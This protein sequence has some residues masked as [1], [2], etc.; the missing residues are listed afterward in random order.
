MFNNKRMNAAAFV[1]PCLFRAQT[2]EPLES[3]STC[4]KCCSASEASNRD[5]PPFFAAIRQSAPS[6]LS[7]RNLAIADMQW[8][9]LKLSVFVSTVGD[10]EGDSNAAGATVEECQFAS[11]VLGELLDK[12]DLVPVD[13]YT[14]EVSTPGTKDVLTKE[15]EF[16]AF[17]GFPINVRTTEVYKKKELF[18][19]TLKD[20]DDEKLLLNI[21]GRILSI[22]RDIIAE[23]RLDTA[24]E[25]S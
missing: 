14:L 15:R 13:A 25:E 24:K 11:V 10:V 12:D 4:P 8:S 3:S 16:E 21:K 18:V 7:G 23:V 17:K 1:N 5:E 19:G 9:D 6:V 2:P 22:P 20:R